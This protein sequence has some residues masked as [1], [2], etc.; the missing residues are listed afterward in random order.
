MRQQK[1][2]KREKRGWQPSL[3]RGPVFDLF[4]DK[5]IEGLKPA[6]S[7]NGQEDQCDEKD[8]DRERALLDELVTNDVALTTQAP[9]FV[10]VLRDL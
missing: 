9:V 8:S 4:I 6:S 3:Q 10:F 7:T 1:K 5:T 2:K